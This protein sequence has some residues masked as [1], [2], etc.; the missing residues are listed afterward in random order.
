MACSGPSH[1]ACG[2]TA[3]RRGERIAK[4]PLGDKS[5]SGSLRSPPS[6]CLPSFLSLGLKGACTFAPHSSRETGLTLGQEPQD[7]RAARPKGAISDDEYVEAKH[8]LLRHHH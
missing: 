6:I 4:T 3:I 7:L 2:L 1:T 5:W 8:K